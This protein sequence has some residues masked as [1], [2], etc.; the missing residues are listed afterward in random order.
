MTDVEMRTFVRYSDL[1]EEPL[2]TLPAI[3]GYEQVPLVNFDEAIEPLLSIVP[4]LPQMIEMITGKCV[5]MKDGLTRS[6]SA[7]IMLYSMQWQ[8]KEQSFNLLLNRT[9]RDDNRER[10]TPWFGYLKLF[11]K[12]LSKLPSI[13]SYVYRA[14]PKDLSQEYGQG[15][16]FL[17]WGF[18]LCTQSIEIVEKEQNFNQ[19]D[20]RT[21][22]KI[23]SKSAK[24][25][26]QH[27]F[28]HLDGELLL[29]AAQCYKVISSLDSGDGLHIIQLKEIDP[30]IV[31]PLTKNDR[32]TSI[33]LSLDQRRTSI[34]LSMQNTSFC[35]IVLKVTVRSCPFGI[36]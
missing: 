4:D 1:I 27:S 11:S 5:E 14:V 10:L 18:A 32:T 8:P 17:W 25:I 3:S 20:Q 35:S 24:D 22:L 15:K 23:E 30:Y 21:R 9:L 2:V 26:R 13:H 12:A 34:N 7:S 31:A 29:P 36:D 19:V 6:E 28:H 16:T 33:S